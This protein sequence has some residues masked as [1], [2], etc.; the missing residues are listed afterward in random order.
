[1]DETETLRAVPPTVSAGGDQ[2]GFI[3]LVMDLSSRFAGAGHG[4]VNTQIRHAL[5]RIVDFFDAD[6]C[7][8]YRVR[9]CEG[10]AIIHE[11][12]E[13]RSKKTIPQ[14]LDA[15]ALFPWLFEEV[16]IRHKT[17]HIPSI[18]DLPTEAALDRENLR[19][20][21]VRSALFIPLSLRNSADLV[22]TLSS[23]RDH[24]DWPAGLVSQLRLL[25]E[26]LASV[27]RRKELEE[28]SEASLRFEHLITCTSARLASAEPEQ[29]PSHIELALQEVLDYTQ[30]DQAGFFT[31][32]EDTGQVYLTHL[33]HVSG[34][35]PGS[36]KIQYTEMFPWLY[37]TLVRRQE[38]FSFSTLDELPPEAAIDCHQLESHGTRSALYIPYIEGGVVRYIFAMVSNT[39]ELHWPPKLVERMQALGGVFVNALA[40][41]HVA[42]AMRRSESGLRDAQRIASLGNW[43]RDVL[44]D[45][46]WTSAQTDL[47]LGSR[48]T[49]HDAFMDSIHP[50]DRENLGRTI[51]TGIA[52][53]GTRYR[54]EHRICRP[55][56]EERVVE[57]HFEIIRS[58]SEDSPRVFGTIQDITARRRSEQELEAL[59]AQQWHAARLTQIAVLISSLAHELCQPLTAILSNAQAALRLIGQ[60]RLERD[61]AIAILEDIVADD[62]RA[63]QVIESLRVMLRRRTSERQI[64]DSAQMARDV[65]ALLRSEFIKQDVLVESDLVAGSRIMG[66]RVQLQQVL[67]NLVMNGME[68]MHDQP[69]DRRRL[70]L[71]VSGNGQDGTVFSVT[72]SGTGLRK[73]DV[74]KVFEAFWTTKQN[75]MGMGLA[76]CHSIIEA[77]GGHLW[78]EN[79]AGHGATFH[80]SLPDVKL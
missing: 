46:V 21:G 23:S 27:L 12:I 38:T 65:I 70:F 15:Q 7:T 28:E 41:Q 77:H 8:L 19:S 9:R 57:N 47:I 17:V 25:S 16:A 10:K 63:G 62:K 22:L 68:A 71:K 20:W 33:K 13:K 60:G 56:G 6:R 18:D 50:D 39:R 78:V 73:E 37:Q 67:I 69:P 52:Q 42:E 54:I 48:V 2:H 1:M 43:E 30:N 11:R 3:E 58:G 75:G 66:D 31:V 29:I 40:R 4:Q 80:F 14:L 64:I 34:I 61:E 24:P 51:E 55:D 53:P 72:D 45:Q 26:T 5:R 59:R 44:T 74:Q 76:I 79:N 49:T 32:F 36:K 35:S